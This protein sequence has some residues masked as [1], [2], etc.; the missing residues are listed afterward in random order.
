[1]LRSR[2]T[3]CSVVSADR[4]LKVQHLESNESGEVTVDAML[5]IAT[6]SVVLPRN[7]AGAARSADL[8][9]AAEERGGAGCRPVTAQSAQLN[10][11]RRDH[12]PTAPRR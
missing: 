3:V 9:F 10:R 7:A 4:M 1:M 6:C 2:A 12:L 5:M 11:S 8:H